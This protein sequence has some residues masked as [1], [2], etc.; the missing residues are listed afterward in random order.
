MRASG[1]TERA[2]R[3]GEPC[4]CAGRPSLQ[5][6][7]ATV[8]VLSTRVAMTTIRRSFCVCWIDALDEGQRAAQAAKNAEASP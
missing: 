4:P 5:F 7:E 1:A 6:P 3:Q 8:A 2:A